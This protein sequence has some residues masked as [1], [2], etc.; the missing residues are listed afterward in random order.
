MCALC[1]LWYWPVQQRNSIYIRFRES[2]SLSFFVHS[3]IIHR[4]NHV[5]GRNMHLSRLKIGTRAHGIR[6]H[7]FTSISER[8]QMRHHME[9]V[10]AKFLLRHLDSQMWLMSIYFMVTHIFNGT[11]THYTRVMMNEVLNH[12][13]GYKNQFKMYQ[14]VPHIN[15]VSFLL[16]KPFNYFVE[17]HRKWEHFLSTELSLESNDHRK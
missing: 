1:K 16:F 10:F 12:R 17:M 4:T 5:R 3:N 6:L 11:L 14:C 9:L 7:S 2:R 13:W 15:F 8:S